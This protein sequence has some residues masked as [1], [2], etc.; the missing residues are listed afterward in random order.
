MIGAIVS[1]LIGLFVDDGFLAAAILAAVATIAS[2]ILLGALPAWLAGLLLTLSMPTA[3]A[4]SVARSA[5]QARRPD[6]DGEPRAP[7]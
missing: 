3:L 2:L 1:Q 5:R 4:A 6:S 7:P